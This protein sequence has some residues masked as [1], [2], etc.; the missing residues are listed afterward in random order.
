MLRAP[1][2]G[3]F[4]SDLE[5]E[6]AHFSREIPF[7]L[8]ESVPF[9]TS[10][11][12]GI[13]SI[14]GN[15]SLNQISAAPS[16]QFAN[17][18]CEAESTEFYFEQSNNYNFI[19]DPSSNVAK[20]I[21]LYASPMKLIEH[22]AT[23]L[24][25]KLMDDFLL[26]LEAFVEPV[27]FAECLIS[28]LKKVFKV[29]AS[30]WLV[31]GE[32]VEVMKM[33]CLV[34]LQ[35]WH[36]NM[37]ASFHEELPQEVCRIVLNGLDQIWTQARIISEADKRLIAKIRRLYDP[38]CEHN[39]YT[40]T[41][42][43]PATHEAVYSD[44]ESDIDVDSLSLQRPKWSAR[45]KAKLKSI[46]SRSNHSQAHLQMSPCSS[47]L[48]TSFSSDIEDR[49]NE[50]CQILLRER[51]KNLATILMAVEA[52]LF[53]AI[54][55]AEVVQFA[56][57][58][59][60]PMKLAST[61]PNLQRSIDHF[62]SMCRWF[63]YVLTTQSDPQT[64]AELLAKLIRLAVKCMLINN[65]NSFLQIVLALQSPVVANL[66]EM[67]EILPSWEQRL[68]RDLAA[69]GSPARN[70]KNIRQAM[71]EVFDGEELDCLAGTV[72]IPFTGLF[73]SDSV[74]NWE[75][76]DEQLQSLPRHVPKPLPVY[77]CHVAA[78]IIRQFRQ[79]KQASLKN[80]IK[81]D[82]KQRALYSYFADIGRL[83]G[84]FL[85]SY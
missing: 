66:T 11:T 77:K 3:F 14:L 29:S 48:I 24:D 83:G 57:S 15:L 17:R 56:K 8:H 45:L 79:F 27:W 65:F 25:Y 84:D 41:T 38:S 9:V 16:A 80:C 7:V 60:C 74:Y 52:D 40:T 58:R 75:Q 53:G 6:A 76:Q 63:A 26:S 10:T 67:W 2:D 21:L 20:P 44:A 36:S 61:C 55:R 72:P 85:E 30:N 62:N 18:S 22:L 70:F 73:L 34:I 82:G 1:P 78:K 71:E 31:S 5:E 46:F 59:D 42:S 19:I 37:A 69:F 23:T 28:L 35:H 13:E 43:A 68:A 47:L 51:S 81:L 32:M 4:D 12:V 64:A 54:G 39:Q 33:R 49:D 50:A